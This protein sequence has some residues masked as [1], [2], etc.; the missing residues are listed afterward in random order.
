MK[1]VEISSAGT[2]STRTGSKS[3]TSCLAFRL[4]ADSNIRAGRNTGTK[5]Y[6][7]SVENQVTHAWTH[8]FLQENPVQSQGSPEQ[9]YRGWANY[10]KHRL[11]AWQSV[12]KP[13]IIRTMASDKG[14][15]NALPEL[16]F[17]KLIPSLHH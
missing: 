11:P 4:K 8:H 7:E 3:L 1:A 5:Q 9:R 2:A 14:I 15:L 17:L 12:N 13:I 16:P 6:L 10:D